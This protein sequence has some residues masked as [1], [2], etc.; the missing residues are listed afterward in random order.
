MRIEFAVD[1]V[2]QHPGHTM[3]A[4]R[5]HEADIDLGD[6]FTVLAEA[7]RLPG[8]TNFGKPIVSYAVAL[9]IDGIEA[10]RHSIEFLSSGMTG[11]LRLIGP[12][13]GLLQKVDASAGHGTWLLLG[14]KIVPSSLPGK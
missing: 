14:E 3:V 11:M 10:Y 6:V 8:A 12:G 9:R 13:R 2:R 4:G 5:V 1:E 7:S